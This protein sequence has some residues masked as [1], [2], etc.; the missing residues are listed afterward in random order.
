MK[1]GGREKGK[2]RPLLNGIRSCSSCWRSNI[3]TKP[4]TACQPEAN[5]P[6]NSS[7]GLYSLCDLDVF[8]TSPTFHLENECLDKMGW[9]HASSKIA[10]MTFSSRYVSM[11]VGFSLSLFRVWGSRYLSETT[12]MG[13]PCPHP[14][15]C[16]WLQSYPEKAGMGMG[17]KSSKIPAGQVTLINEPL[18]SPII[19]T[20]PLLKIIHLSVV[21]QET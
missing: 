5:K 18:I 9:V 15:H 1:G 14:A 12:K 16:L 20:T 8:L 6:V 4:L 7:T 21:L 11:Q 10:K 17:R 13:V 2:R 19:L 3:F